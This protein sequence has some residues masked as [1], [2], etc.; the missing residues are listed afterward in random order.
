ML[1]QLGVVDD[2]VVAAEGGVLVLDGV[3]AVRAAGDDLLGARLVEGGDVHL[4]LL[5]V[6]VLVAEAPHRVAG[7]RLLGAEDAEGDAG[8]VQ[9]ARRGLHALA[10]PLVEGAGAADPVEVLD[11]VGDG[12]GDDRDL[13]VEALGPLGALVLAEAPGVALVL[14]V[15]QHEPG[16]GGELGLHEHL[17]AAHVDDGVDVLDVDRALVHAGAAGGAGPQH[18]GVDDVGH[19]GGLLALAGEQRGGRGE[20]VVAQ[21]HD[22]QLGRERLVRGPG[23]AGRL[24][25]PALG[26]GGEVEHLLPGEVADLADAEHGV[27][28]DVLHVHVG[29]AVEGAEGPGAPREGDV[30]R[31]EEDVQV[32]GVRDE[33]DEARD[34]GD[35]EEQEDGHQHRVGPGAERGAAAWPRLWEAK[36]PQP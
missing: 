21:A 31:R 17:V 25:A 7:A 4:R 14:D 18:V 36:A 24:A 16:L 30:D 9:H 28:V 29:R 27:L 5:L 2:L 19:Q 26:T 32:L 11:V 35:V 8:P 10:G 13:E 34:D 20:H 12:A 15:A 3:E 1:E 6:Q 22:E 23:G 33:D